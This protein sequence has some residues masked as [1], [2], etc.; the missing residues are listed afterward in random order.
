MKDDLRARLT[1]ANVMSIIAVF[2]ALGGV[3]Y[4]ALTLPKNSVGT[5]QL[6]RNAVKGPKVANGSLTGLDINES[7]LGTVPRSARAALADTLGGKP[8][9]DFA[10]ASAEPWHEVGSLGTVPSSNYQFI[11]WGAGRDTVGYYRDP[12][13]VVRIKGFI[14]LNY[15]PNGPGCN[16][17]GPSAMTGPIFTLPAGYRPDNTQELPTS[18]HGFFARVEIKPDGVVSADG[19][20]AW[21]AEDFYLDGISFRCAPSGQ[22][23]CP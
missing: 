4:A 11:N 8:A 17:T 12:Y 3:G 13:G 18:S 16:L 22:N 10:P 15:P 1:F 20:P 14:C 19:D 2:I 9:S 7:T 6:K 5:K 23:G 21:H